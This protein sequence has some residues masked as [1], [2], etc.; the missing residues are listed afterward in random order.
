MKRL[1]KR[2]LVPMLH[3]GKPTCV[4]Q[5]ISEIEISSVSLSGGSRS[6]VWYEPVPQHLIGWWASYMF[7]DKQQVSMDL[8]NRTGNMTH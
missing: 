4:F 8:L 2:D 6:A 1:H 5:V 7:T 3:H